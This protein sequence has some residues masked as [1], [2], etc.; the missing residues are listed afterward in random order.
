MTECNQPQ[1]E[2]EGH[3]SRRVVAQFDRCLHQ[4]PLMFLELSLEA[5]EQG[6]R[7][8]GRSGKTCQNFFAE[9]APRLSRRMLHDVF[10]HGD[11]SVGGDDNLIVVAH[12]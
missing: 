3:F 2:F 9:Q 12:A 5:L 10:A 7:V 1:F 4:I 11:L 8:R 6:K